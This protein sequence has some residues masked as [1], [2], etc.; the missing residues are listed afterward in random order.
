VLSGALSPSQLVK[1]SSDQLANDDVATLRN[2]VRKRKLEELE[3]WTASQDLLGN[4]NDYTCINCKSTKCFV[5]GTG[6]RGGWV[7]S[8]I[9]ASIIVTCCDCNVRWEAG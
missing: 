3:K 9:E 5:N 6:T 2:E 1:M 4:S 8:Q 7:S